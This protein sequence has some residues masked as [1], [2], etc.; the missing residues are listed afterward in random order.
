MSISLYSFTK[1][2]QNYTAT[3][4]RE[5]LN[6]RPTRWLLLFSLLIYED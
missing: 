2:R 6:A 3:L 5:Y 4:Y 1:T